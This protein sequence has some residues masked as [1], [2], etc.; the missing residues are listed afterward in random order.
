[1]RFNSWVV[2][3]ACFSAVRVYALPT[4]LITG[5]QSISPGGGSITNLLPDDEFGY[6]N[7]DN[8]L[9]LGV[10]NGGAALIGTNTITSMVADDIQL[11]AIANGGTCDAIGIAVA[12]FSAGSIA[13]RLGMRFYAANG[14]GGAPGTILQALTFNALAFPP[15]VVG[16]NGPIPTFTVPANG[17]LWVGLLFDDSNGTLGTEIAELNSL[18]AGLFNPPTA[19]SSADLLFDSG[20]AGTFLQNNPPGST[21]NFGGPPVANI[22]LELQVTPIPEPAIAGAITMLCLFSLSLRER[23]GVRASGLIE[24]SR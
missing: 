11:E 6:S 7:L 9:G 23:V 24:I 2:I 5:P 1:M 20:V 10:M 16:L 12:N 8:F 17:K 4:A 15:G 22:G 19:G 3:F 14:A 13:A 18:G 21:G